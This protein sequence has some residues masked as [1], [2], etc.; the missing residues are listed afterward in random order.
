LSQ[1]KQHKIE[2]ALFLIVL[3]IISIGIYYLGP[4][5]TGFVI[6]EVSYTKDLN[7]VVTSSGN[8][9]LELENIGELKSLK[10]DGRATSYGNSKVYIESNGIKYL[11]FDSAKLSESADNATISNET[12]LI[13]G[14]ATKEDDE[15]N[16]EKKQA[17][18]DENKKKKNKKPRWT[19]DD[20]FIINGATEINLSKFFA[21]KDGDA[22]IYSAS[23]VE[24]L[25]VSID[26]EIVAIEPK[27]DKD[28]NTTI[29][30]IASD[31]IDSKSKIVGLIVIADKQGSQKENNAPIWNSNISTFITNGTTS[32][33]LS[34]YFIDEDNDSLAY[35]S[36]LVDNVTITINGELFTLIPADDYF[37]TVLTVFTAYDG[38]NLT[39][40]EV[41]LT[42]PEKISNETEKINKAPKWKSDIDSFILN[43]SLSIDLLDYFD[44][45]NFLSFSVSDAVDIE[46]KINDSLLTLNTSKDNFNSTLTVTASDGDSNA[47]KDI[48]IIVPLTI[49]PIINETNITTQITINLS[50]NAGTIYDAN[51]NGEESI[52]GVVDLTVADTKFRWEVDDT[53]LC[54][55]WEIYN[56][57]EKTLTTFCNGN[58]DCCAFIELLPT[59][60]NWNEVY[61]STF[62]KD[63]A[64][65]DNIISAQVIYYDVNLS[66][67]NLKSEIYI[68]EWSNL[69][70]K[71]FEDE[72]DFF[73]E[74]IETCSLIGLNKSSYTLIFEIE[75]DAVL[76]IDKIKYRL[77]ANI[78]NNP[79]ILLQ[80]FT[81]INISKNKIVTLNLSQYFSDPDGDKLSYNYYKA[82]NLRIL[83]ENN[84]ATFVPDEGI[85]GTRY[86]YIIAND[87]ELT[88]VSN[89]FAINI[90]KRK[91]KKI[92][93][94]HVKVNPNSIYFND[95]EDTLDIKVNV[96]GLPSAHTIGYKIVQDVLYP[97]FNFAV[98][99]NAIAELLR[100]KTLNVDYSIDFDYDISNEINNLRPERT[101][102]L[103]SKSLFFKPA[104]YCYI[105]NS[106][107]HVI[108]GDIINKEL[109][110]AN[111]I[112]FTVS[113]ELL[114]NIDDGT[115]ITCEDPISTSTEINVTMDL[116]AT[117][118]GNFIGTSTV[119]AVSTDNNTGG[120]YLG[121]AGGKLGYY[122]ES[123]N[124]THDLSATD[125]GNWIGTTPVYYISFDPTGDGA[126]F[127]GDVEVGANAIFGYYNKST[128]ITHDLRITKASSSGQQ[129]VDWVS[130]DTINGGAYFVTRLGRF[131]Y[132]NKTS[133]ETHNLSATDIGG[134]MGTTDINTVT[135]NSIDGGAYI[136]LDAGR[137]GYYNKSA[138]S[139][140]DLRST[141]TG[142]WIGSNDITAMAFDSLN[143]G[144]YI[145]GAN[146][147]FGYYNRTTNVTHDLR[148][149]NSGV[150]F[151]AA[152]DFNDVTFE[153]VN[154][155]AYFSDSTGQYFYYNKSGNY[156]HNLTDTD[157]GNWFGTSSMSAMHF[158]PKNETVYV[159]GAGGRFGVYLYKNLSLV[160]TVSDTTAPIVNTTFNITNPIVGDVINFT[161]NVTDETALLSANWTVNL[162]SGTLF[163]NYTLSGTTAQ[164]SN[165]TILSSAGV[166]NFTLYVT[167]TS[168]N[169]KQNSTLITV[170]QAVNLA[171]GGAF[172]VQN[173][174][175]SSLAVIDSTGTMNIKGSLTQNIEPPTADVN[176][177]IV[178]NSSGGYN[179]VITNPE[180]N[181]L[182]KNSLTQNQGTLSPTLSSFVVQN[183]TGA[184]VAYV[185]STGGLFLVGSLAENVV[186]G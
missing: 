20:E 80:N 61:Y 13:I 65:H 117:D 138:N 147:I 85:E 130:T 78:Q 57:G 143:D 19:G 134:W 150:R 77:L 156:T 41:A 126:Y 106:F 4:A 70:A 159:G 62:N 23:E 132:Y 60:T 64:G 120:A 89:V 127:I 168:N 146:G 9:T 14:F 10:L 63:G 88:A 71:F 28:F 145:A 119:H 164:V 59:K 153:S 8:Y 169:V 1:N 166:F 29:T 107:E 16:K 18:D 79:P 39:S 42:V 108:G 103:K 94:E 109:L 110:N 44:D 24:G 22:L 43:K 46:E 140:I 33:N 186:F 49:T 45:D 139:T 68:S 73:D 35:S 37:G 161:G 175:G 55:R 158:N 181:L 2:L 112:K 137:Y 174:S 3:V 113:Y 104:F 171:A 90:E 95:T 151:S 100:N 26:G 125:V 163:M 128:N 142:D 97:N 185:N 11:I 36:G 21:D 51:D 184:T 34:E 25:D 105:N 69:S 183:N 7:L 173:A 32:L 133:N 178:Q 180:G 179:L 172:I 160:A 81:A 30:F 157:T 165:K 111:T 99:N 101:I 152:N 129:I 177:F 38:K 96:Q 116:S 154:G 155:G 67:D 98:Q 91:I 54:T 47:S 31:G 162:S 48:K 40:K 53:K 52:N 182:I 115:L 167:D 66:A 6:K 58:A 124:I 76:R 118:V 121:M 114:D 74:C 56:E 144:F 149:T 122:N 12:S 141:D 15:K 93:P 82:D 83:F 5:I 170:Y 75:D 176:D 148:T 87:S 135:F 17:E 72:I 102:P 84:S 86:S 50:Y 92:K 136:G 123:T 27:T 131:Y